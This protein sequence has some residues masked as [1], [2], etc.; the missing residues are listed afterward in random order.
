MRFPED[1]KERKK[2]PVVTGVLEYFPDAIV[3]VSR[4]S[5]LGNDQHNPGME[6]HWNRS[7]SM[8]QAN[9]IGRHL[10]ERGTFDVDGIRHSARLAWRALALLQLEIEAEGPASLSVPLQVKDDDLF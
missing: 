6:L 8:D 7:K 3:E 4:V 1:P 2:F 9:A 5:M 10:L